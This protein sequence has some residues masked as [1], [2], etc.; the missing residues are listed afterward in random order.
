MKVII[1]TGKLAE[2]LVKKVSDRSKQD[3]FVHVVNTP[4]AAFL[5]PKKI[6]NEVKVIESHHSIELSDVDM[7]I[8]PG[9]IRKDAK[10]IQEETGIPAYKGPT[11]AADLQIV[12]DA[13][14]KLELST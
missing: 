1:I 3:V 6:S 10:I 12:L 7:I 11:D 9:L 2:A 13:L 4:I 5:T 14:D 8:I